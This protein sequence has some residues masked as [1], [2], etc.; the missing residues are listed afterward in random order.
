MTQKSTPLS[1]RN[2]IGLSVDRLRH[3]RFIAVPAGKVTFFPQVQ[4]GHH[5]C[6]RRGV[7]FPPNSRKMSLCLLLKLAPTCAMVCLSVRSMHWHR[8][9]FTDFGSS[10]P[11]AN[12]SPAHRTSR[13]QLHKRREM[14]I[15]SV[16]GAGT[17]CTATRA[18]EGRLLNPIYLKAVVASFIQKWFLC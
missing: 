3:G 12:L 7:P 10:S 5:S 18:R 16:G 14:K 9:D 11:N 17:D 4:I 1:I 2:G 15:V 13:S 8:D 6:D